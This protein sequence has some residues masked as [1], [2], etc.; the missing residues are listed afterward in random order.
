MADSI[1]YKNKLDPT[2]GLISYINEIKPYHSKIVDVVVEYQTSDQLIGYVEDRYNMEI[3]NTNVP[4]EVTYTCGYGLSWDPFGGQSASDIP[5]ADIVEIKKFPDNYIVVKFTNPPSINC[6]VSNLV[7]NQITFAT[8]YTISGVGPAQQ[9]WIVNGN[10]TSLLSEGSVIFVSNNQYGNGRYTVRTTSFSSSTNK[11]TVYVIEPISIQATATGNFN[12]PLT[13]DQLPYWP[14]H[15]AI[16]LQSTNSLPNPIVSTTQ[17]YFKR[18]T[19]QSTFNLSKVRYWTANSDLVDLTTYENGSLTVQQVQ[20]FVPGQ[21]INVSVSPVVNQPF[22]I[23]DIT[24]HPTKPNHFIVKLYEKL[25]ND[26]T[27][28]GST[29]IGQAIYFGSYG[30]PKCAPA[31]VGEGHVVTMLYESVNIAIS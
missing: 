19:L 22:T 1:E 11:T 7:S 6:V 17:Y 10:L 26:I 24:N 2:Y 8:P 28:S 9:R 14:E 3:T 15:L 30:D 29:V 31:T 13:D 18:T 21:F 23:A 27:S 25:D 20:P 12:I 4:G 5:K 16:K